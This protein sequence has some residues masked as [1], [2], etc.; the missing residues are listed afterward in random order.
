MTVFIYSAKFDRQKASPRHSFLSFGSPKRRSSNS[1]SSSRTRS[2]SGPGSPVFDA[3][4]NNNNIKA[5]SNN[6]RAAEV[7]KQLVAATAARG[8]TDNITVVV[9]ELDWGNSNSSKRSTFTRPIPGRKS[10]YVPKKM[11]DSSLGHSMSHHNQPPEGGIGGGRPQV[12]EISAMEEKNLAQLTRFY[13][14]HD[15]SSMDKAPGLAKAAL[16]DFVSVRESLR[17]KYDDVPGGWDRRKTTF[18]IKI[19]QHTVTTPVKPQHFSQRKPGI[20]EYTVSLQR[21]AVNGLGLGLEEV[22]KK[23]GGGSNS[24]QISVNEIIPGTPADSNSYGSNKIQLG[25]DLV[26]VN[27]ETVTILSFEEVLQRLKAPSV[28]LTFTRDS[29]WVQGLTGT[30]LRSGKKLFSVI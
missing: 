26:A 2:S 5:S 13:A 8:S 11:T 25:D 27:G 21:S 15:P 18:D 7:A 9:V 6:E 16:D 28:E 1:N 23:G 10:G 14:V 19:S 17:A 4:S 22:V 20:I 12:E 24:P 30:R 3:R 29:A